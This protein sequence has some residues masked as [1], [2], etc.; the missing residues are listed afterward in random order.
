ML[1][2]LEVTKIKSD[3]EN[4][5]K[6]AAISFK[7]GNSGEVLQSFNSSRT[8][9][10][11]E[12]FTKKESLRSLKKLRKTSTPHDNS[13]KDDLEILLQLKGNEWR[14]LNR[15]FKVALREQK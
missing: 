8:L 4:K 6:A 15:A 5:S 1:Y 11:S 2:D 3:V 14:I 10:F 7:H 12:K 13:W 9:S